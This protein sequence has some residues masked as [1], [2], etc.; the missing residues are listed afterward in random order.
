MSDTEKTD[1]FGFSA[2][3][4]DI[5]DHYY[6]TIG[7]TLFQMVD[8]NV[9]ISLAAQFAVRVILSCWANPLPNRP[10]FLSAAVM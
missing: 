4:M 9:N 8:E 5:D 2:P 10:S 3:D 6:T 7:I 1:I